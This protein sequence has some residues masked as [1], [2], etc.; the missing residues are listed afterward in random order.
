MT[1]AHNDAFNPPAPRSAA[2]TDFVR[3]LE[4]SDLEVGELRAAFDKTV[5]QLEREDFA[6]AE[7]KKLTPEGLY[8]AKLNRSD[9]LLFQIMRYREER[10]ALVLEV[11]RNHAYDK[12]RF[13]NGAAI[14]ED[15]IPPLAP[16]ELVGAG[17]GMVEE[18]DDV[19]QRRLARAR[20]PHD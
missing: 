9:R 10:C 4:Y 19:E 5:A 12:S 2:R 11:V 15:K 18:P 16:V 8:R 1:P 20:R 3:V 7:V 14:Q 6:S 17:A 13:L